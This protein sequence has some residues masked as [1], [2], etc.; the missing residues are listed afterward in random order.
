MKKE[1]LVEFLRSTIESDAI[2]SRLYR[3]F[4]L[5][6][7][8]SLSELSNIIYYG[9]KKNYFSIEN[10]YDEKIKYE[11]IDWRLDNIE[12]EVIMNEPEKYI[13]RLFSE[14]VEI[15]EEFLLFL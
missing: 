6:Y 14:N 9:V 12:Q 2:I 11:K 4:H 13:G 8:Y 3:L 10:V 15:P 1:D 7:G 5:E